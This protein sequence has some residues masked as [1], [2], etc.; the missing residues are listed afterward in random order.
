MRCSIS[1]YSFHQRIKRGEITQKDTVRLAAEMGF[2]GIE[3][4][5]LMPNNEKEPTLEAQLAFAAELRAEAEACGIAIVAYSIGASLY[6]GDA[7]TDLAEVTR[8]CGQVDVAAALGAPV[9]RHD[10]CYSTVVNGKTVS[11]DRQLPTIADNARKVTIY[12]E[13]KG[14]R[15]C[16]E[17]HGFVAQ[18]SERMERLYNTVAHD[19]YGLLVDVGNFSCVDEPS[20]AAVSR[21]AP[22]AC[23]VHV[24]DMLVLP[25]GTPREP[26]RSYITTRGCNLLAC[27]TVGEGSIP[28]SQ[29]LAILRRAGY[30]GW[31]SLEYEGKKD[32]MTEIP[33]ALARIKEYIA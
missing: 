26:D 30:D 18:D 1:S 29:C 23:H 24:K 4:T 13:T 17:N 3:F 7:E 12:A 22:Y 19:N 31:I 20:P 27:C 6:K 15:T 9:M 25:Y 5:D 16:S 33:V 14:V 28:V 21:V 2:E 11:F 10:V 32:C 8:L